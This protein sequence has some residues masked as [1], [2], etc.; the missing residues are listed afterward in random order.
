MFET[1]SASSGYVDFLQAQLKCAGIR[2]RLITAEIDS[3]SAALRG[4]FISADD[5]MIW[6]HEAGGLGLIAVSSAIA[7]LASS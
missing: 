5:A 3:I 4:N 7:T 1:S 2:A 6:L